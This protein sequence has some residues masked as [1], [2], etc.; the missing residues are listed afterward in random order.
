MAATA[1]SMPPESPSTTPAIQVKQN[2]LILHDGHAGR[3]RSGSP[4]LLKVL[5]RLLRHLSAAGL[6]PVTLRAALRFLTRE[7]A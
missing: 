2:I 7:A 1:E 6:R 4:V 5:P 3:T